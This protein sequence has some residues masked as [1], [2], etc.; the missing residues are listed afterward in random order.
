[1][2][3]PGGAIFSGIGFWA[4]DM[5][6]G[7]SRPAGGQGFAMSSSEM[8]AMLKKA[9]AQRETL[10][11]QMRAAENLSKARPPAEEPVSQAAV[12]G[13]N[14]VN[15]TGVYYQGHLQYQFNYYSELIS[16][17]HQ[18]LGITEAADQQAADSTKT[19]KGTLE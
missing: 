9:E 11:E 1:M 18:A 6:S 15:E 13:P 7:A 2:T 17:L 19:I 4:T 5:P 16:R 14:G 10:I 3:A 8:R 12:N